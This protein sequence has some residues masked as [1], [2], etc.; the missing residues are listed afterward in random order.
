MKIRFL[1]PFFR[2]KMLFR[3]ES[4]PKG[5]TLVEL[6]LTIAILGILSI[7]FV[8]ILMDVLLSTRIHTSAQVLVKDIHSAQTLAS[9]TH[10]S[11]W[12]VFD[13]STDEYSIYTGSSIQ[14]RTLVKNPLTQSDWV[15]SL[16]DPKYKGADFTSVSFG[17]PPSTELL[18]NP[19]GDAMSGGTIVFN[20]G[21]LTVQVTELTGKT[22]ILQ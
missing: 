15:V 17:S 8:P 10:D 4:K 13:T 2:S 22:E 18:F 6:I 11:I 3:R 12:V 14:T 5:F 9:T 21:E 1:I 20:N 19:W 7:V 16:N